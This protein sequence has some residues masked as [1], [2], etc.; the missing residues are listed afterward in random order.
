MSEFVIK[1]HISRWIGGMYVGVT[2]LVLS[3]FFGLCGYFYFNPPELTV[4]AAVL[5]P[6]FLAAMFIVWITTSFFETKYTIELGVL[7]ARSPFM[8]IE[9]RLKDV[10]KAE[11]VMVPAH[12]RVGAS[13]YCGWFYVPNV[14]GVRSIITNLRD[15]VMMTTKDGKRYMITPSEPERFIRKIMG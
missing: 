4:R 11:R 10:V 5:V 1:P 9:V 3:I 14:G 8:R 7:R 2:I 15:A 12:F 13:L 6:L